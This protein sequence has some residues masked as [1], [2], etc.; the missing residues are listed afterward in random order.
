MK[1]C[2]RFVYCL[3]HSKHFLHDSTLPVNHIYLVALQGNCFLSLQYNCDPLYE[4]VRMFSGASNK[5]R[6]LFKYK[7][8][9]GPHF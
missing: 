6:A 2:L 7:M 8:V 9:D 5:V 4:E 3:T 1:E